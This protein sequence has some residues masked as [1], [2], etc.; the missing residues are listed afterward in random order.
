MWWAC[1]KVKTFWETIYN[2]LKKIFQYTF[3]KKPEAFLL[4]MV[5]NEIK[6]R[7]QRFFLYATTAARILLAQNW[8]TPNL[9]KVEEWRRKLLE[10]LEMAK[11]TSRIRNQ[12]D[13]QIDVDWCKFLEYL[14]DNRNV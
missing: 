1:G 11:L 2:E 3:P 5:G 9:P 10:Y 7:D 14:K 13:Q 4:G 12:R 8:N 6:K